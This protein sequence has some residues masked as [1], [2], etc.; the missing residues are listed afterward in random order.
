MTSVD[1]LSHDEPV[2]ASWVQQIPIG[3]SIDDDQFS[4]RHRAITKVLFAHFPVLLVI[5]LLRGYA[6]WHALLELA[7]ILVMG[8]LAMAPQT[9]LGKSLSSSMGLIYAASALVHFTGGITEAHFHW[10]AILSLCA[11]YVPMFG[12]SWLQLSTPRC[13]TLRWLFTT[14]HSS[15]STSVDKNS[16]SS[17]RQSMW[18]SW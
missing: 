6:L 7:P 8:A 14:Q 18:C 10:F 3:K 17:G 11:L 1:A 5:A 16:R 2:T 4:F 12:R 15:S 13:I 9:R